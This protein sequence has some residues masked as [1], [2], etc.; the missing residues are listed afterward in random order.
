MATSVL[1]LI[2]SGPSEMLK[3]QTIAVPVH[4]TFSGD[5]EVDLHL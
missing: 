4:L 5:P 3:S 1:L 2:S